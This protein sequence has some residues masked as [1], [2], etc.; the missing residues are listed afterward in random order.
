MEEEFLRRRTRRS[1]SPGRSGRLSCAGERGGAARRG[2]ADAGE[3]QLGPA[4]AARPQMSALVSLAGGCSGAGHRFHAGRWVGVGSGVPTP[5]LAEERGPGPTPAEERGLGSS[6]GKA[7]GARESF[8]GEGGGTRDPACCG[9]R[10]RRLLQRVYARPF[11]LWERDGGVA[12]EG[13]AHPVDRSRKGVFCKT[14]SY[15]RAVHA[16][17]WGK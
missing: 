8:G 13:D 10:R 17:R 1:S 7:V 9:D 6:A 12:S 14:Y 3:E 15:R 5:T 11:R 4:V 16:L 2:G